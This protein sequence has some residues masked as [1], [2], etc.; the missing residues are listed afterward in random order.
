MTRNK[1]KTRLSNAQVIEMMISPTAALYRLVATGRIDENDLG[2]LQL[3]CVLAAQIENVSRIDAPDSTVL[4][5]LTQQIE[6][7]MA[8]LEERIEKSREWLRQYADYLR[9]VPFEDVRKAIAI[10]QKSCREPSHA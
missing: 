3:C 5:R 4:Y 9:R 1:K 7:G 6:A 8:V 2:A 10:V